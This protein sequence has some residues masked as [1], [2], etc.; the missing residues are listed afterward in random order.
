MSE[1]LGFNNCIDQSWYLLQ[2]YP[3]TIFP[4]YFEAN[5]RDQKVYLQTAHY[6][7]LNDKDIKISQSQFHYHA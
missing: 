3:P 1:S 6:V 4:D 7:S 5:F 2:L